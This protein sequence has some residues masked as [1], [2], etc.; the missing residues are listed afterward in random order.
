MR[1]GKINYN[2]GHAIEASGYKKRVSWKKIIKYS[3]GTIE[4]YLNQRG[5]RAIH[6]HNTMNLPRIHMK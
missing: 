1:Y 6:F 5:S 2:E 3:N 4:D